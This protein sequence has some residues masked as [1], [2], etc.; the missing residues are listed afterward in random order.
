MLHAEWSKDLVIGLHPNLQDRRAKIEP[1]FVAF[2]SDAHDLN[3]LR[4]MVSIK[5]DLNG[6]S[7][8]MLSR[9]LRHLKCKK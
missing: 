2:E 1:H 3:P 5:D 7:D 9:L 8:L 4:V 6:M